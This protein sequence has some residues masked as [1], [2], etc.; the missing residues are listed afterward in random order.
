MSLLTGSPQHTWLQWR[1]D[2]CEWGS[3][4]SWLPSAPRGRE[5]GPVYQRCGLQP[6]PLPLPAEAWVEGA[7]I[8]RPL[9]PPLALCAPQSWGRLY[10][11]WLTA[12][13]GVSILICSLPNGVEGFA[14]FMLHTEAT[15]WVCVSGGVCVRERFICLLDNKWFYAFK[16]V[17]ASLLWRMKAIKDSLLPTLHFTL[18]CC[19]KIYYQT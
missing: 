12:S 11:G 3:V 15:V 10:F 4:C 14:A 1:N 6:I 2:C 16:S 7:V 18:Y 8:P 9:L 13:A 19:L 5:P 17:I